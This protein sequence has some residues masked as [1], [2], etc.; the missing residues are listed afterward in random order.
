[1]NTNKHKE[2]DFDSII[3]LLRK[4]YLS[5]NAKNLTKRTG[6]IV[7]DHISRGLYNSSVCISKQLHARYD[8]I[9][10][11]VDYIIE[12]LEKDFTNVPL[13]Q[14]KEKLLA[15]VDEEYKKLGPFVNIFLVNTGLAS[16]STLKNFEQGINSKK[17]GVKQAIETKIAIIE[18][19]RSA[20]T[21]AVKKKPWYEKAWLYIAGI[22]VFL[23]AILAIVW[24][25]VDLKERFFPRK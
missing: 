13:E 23:A 25:A 17:V 21:K 24:Y 19:R 16:Q 3:E 20:T 2:K 6:E 22:V 12:S 8:H 7:Q 10:S 11:L 14:C 18:K 9:N 5:K 1:M 4:D 15:I